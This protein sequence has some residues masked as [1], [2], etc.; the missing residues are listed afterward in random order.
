MTIIINKTHHDVSY[1]IWIA[2]R[3]LETSI[4]IRVLTQSSHVNHPPN[5]PPG[6]SS[7]PNPPP[8]LQ[9]N[10]TYDCVIDF[11]CWRRKTVANQVWFLDSWHCKKSYHQNHHYS[12]LS[13]FRTKFKIEKPSDLWHVIWK[14]TLLNIIKLKH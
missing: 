10:R 13:D 6:P 14:M 4:T 11:H 9:Y 1:F 7:P 12:K 8:P 5:Q 2:D 3:Y